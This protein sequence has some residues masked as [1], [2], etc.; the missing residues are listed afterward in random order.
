M[1]KL[2]NKLSIKYYILTIN[3]I[4]FFDTALCQTVQNQKSTSLLDNPV[5]IMIGVGIGC[6]T[7][8]LIYKAFKPEA[9]TKGVISENIPNKGEISPNTN[10]E[11]IDSSTSMECPTFGGPGVMKAH[12]SEGWLPFLNDI[13]PSMAPPS[14]S[15]FNDLKYFQ[16]LNVRLI[17]ENNLMETI[18]LEELNK[19][20]EWLNQMLQH[21][22]IYKHFLD[23]LHHESNETIVNFWSSLL[24]M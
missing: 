16:E 21:E 4:G 19:A 23:A 17:T 1:L 15:T 5:C 6:I 24:P 3:C 22:V 11:L 8:Y 9:S 18:T 2:K 10:S 12:S 20:K 7:G 13:S 14:K